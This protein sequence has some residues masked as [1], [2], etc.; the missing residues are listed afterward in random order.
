M[1]E[2]S[3]NASESPILDIEPTSILLFWELHVLKLGQ[4]LLVNLNPIEED[5]KNSVALVNAQQRLWV[6][7]TQFSS[8]I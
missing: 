1:I 6:N 3:V 8:L 5:R 7:F 4:Y 2:H